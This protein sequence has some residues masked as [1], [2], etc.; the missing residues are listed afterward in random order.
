MKVSNT[1]FAAITLCDVIFE[2]GVRSKL[3][4]IFSGCGYKSICYVMLA[5]DVLGLNRS[6]LRCIEGRVIT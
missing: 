1:V 2:K 6:A 4:P 5:R 3:C